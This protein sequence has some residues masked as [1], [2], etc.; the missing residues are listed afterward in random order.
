MSNIVSLAIGVVI[1]LGLA[2]AG[3]NLGEIK[4]FVMGIYSQLAS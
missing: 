2:Q 1:G 3:V 4:E